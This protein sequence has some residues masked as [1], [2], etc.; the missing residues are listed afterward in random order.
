MAFLSKSQF[1]KEL[2]PR[3]EV[4]SIFLVKHIAVMHAKDGRSYL[5]VVL[6]DNTGDLEARSW[7]R[8]EEISG[9]VKKGDFVQA[10]GKVNRYQGRK[11]LIISGIDG[12]MKDKIDIDDFLVKA[13]RPAEDMYSDLIALVERLDDVYIRDLLKLILEDKEIS[14]RLKTWQAGNYNPM[15]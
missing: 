10:K 3:D 2:R 12:L 9:Q 6:G 15:I 14:R 5:N 4:D 7:Q 8:A 1:V 11:Q 13:A